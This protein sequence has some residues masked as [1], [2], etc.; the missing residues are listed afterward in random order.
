MIRLSSNPGWP[1]LCWTPRDGLSISIAFPATQETPTVANPPFD[2]SNLFNASELA[3]NDFRSTDPQWT[4]PVAF[5]QRAAWDGSF[6]EQPDIPLHIEA[7][8]YRGKPVYF[9]MFGPW[10][11]R[12]RLGAADQSLRD[13]L[14]QLWILAIEVGCLAGGGFLARR[15]LK[16]GRGD[17]KGAFRLAVYVFTVSIL[18]WVL[19]A[20]HPPSSSP[21]NGVIPVAWATPVVWALYIVAFIW[22][23]YIALEPEV[24]QRW[25]HRIVSWSRLLAGRW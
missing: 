10:T 18:S 3:M 20:N 13:R 6:P 16:L 22:L 17:R 21:I 14:L 23:F 24:R 5:D 9:E 19:R 1:A 25:P 11:R 2:W 15:N 12:A 8:A 4:P 7:A